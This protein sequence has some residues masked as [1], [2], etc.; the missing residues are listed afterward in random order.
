MRLVIEG[1]ANE[2]AKIA[3]EIFEGIVEKKGLTCVAFVG[4]K[5]EIRITVLDNEE[6]L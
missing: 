5:D 3:L 6:K 1:K 2:I 4:G